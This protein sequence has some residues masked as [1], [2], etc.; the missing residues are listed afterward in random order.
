MDSG[1]YHF[2]TTGFSTES[3]SNQIK[4][5]AE[6]L[7]S[8]Y[9][10]QRFT[11]PIFKYDYRAG[12]YL[13]KETK[14]GFT[15]LFNTFSEVTGGVRKS[16]WFFNETFLEVF[17]ANFNNYVNCF[18]K[19]NSQNADVATSHVDST[20]GFYNIFYVTSDNANYMNVR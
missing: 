16:A 8:D 6:E 20:S 14:E 5:E 10:Y 7:S 17:N 18:T 11:N 12:N 3:T 2:T 15:F 13:P 19:F 4:R 1:D 9:R